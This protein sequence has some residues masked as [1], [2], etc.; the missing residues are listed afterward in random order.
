MSQGGNGTR[1][2]EYQDPQLGRCVCLEND[3]YQLVAP[4]GFG[5]RILHFSRAGGENLFYQQPAEM[6]ELTHPGG[7]RL[8]GGHRLWA[9]PE[10]EHCYQPD[11]LP[12]TW[13]FREDT[14]TLL[15]QSAAGEPLEK[16]M[17]VCLAQDHVQVA[18]RLKN[19]GSQ[20]LPLALWGITSLCPGGCQTI[21][22]AQQHQPWAPDRTVTLWNGA[23]LSN[24]QLSFQP[25]QMTLRHQ[26]LP[27][28]IKLGVR[29]HQGPARYRL[30]EEEFCLWANWPLGNYPDGGVNYETYLCRHMVEMETLSP[31]YRLAPGEGQE[32]TEF[33]RIDHHVDNP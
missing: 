22:L 6:Q 33:W 28:P 14:L 27:S 13:T 8:Y 24:P 11:N 17:R 1:A 32:H 31:L 29:M 16:S 26:A 21:P 19:E 25:G 9:A 3:S 5:I 20:P 30:G 4:L 18:H 23:D 15:Q 2:A 12:V 10:G 7:W